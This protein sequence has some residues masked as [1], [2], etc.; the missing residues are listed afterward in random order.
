MNYF[1]IFFFCLYQAPLNI[2]VEKENI[3]IIKLL[4]SKDKIN[5]NQR[6]IFRFSNFQSFF[7]LYFIKFALL[8]LL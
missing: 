4:L 3:E 5:V 7:F 2:A 1:M 8:Y 6:T